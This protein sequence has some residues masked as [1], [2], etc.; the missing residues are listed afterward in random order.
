MVRSAEDIETAVASLGGYAKGLY[1]EK[2]VPFVCELAVMV[3]RSR[4]GTVASFP[5]VLTIH[6]D[7]ILL[8][9]EAPA[10]VPPAVQAAAAAVA[11][12]AVGCLE[13]AGVFGVSRRAAARGPAC[14]PLGLSGQALYQN[15]QRQ[16]A[17]HFTNGLIQG[18]LCVLIA[19][20]LMACCAC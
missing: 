18:V 8:T 15:C 13:G 9:T 20:M 19:S 12:R 7:S 1:A 3:V 5:V 2:W 11:E 10:P 17:G 16:G 14:E 6:R 4:D